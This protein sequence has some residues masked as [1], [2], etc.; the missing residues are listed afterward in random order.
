VIEHCKGVHPNRLRH[1]YAHDVLLNG[2]QE[3][4]LMSLAG[5][6]WHAMLQ[7]YG[8]AAADLRAREAAKR[9]RRGDRV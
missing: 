1:S 9:V 3:R 6:S 4:D 8:A 7:R 5:W 2:G